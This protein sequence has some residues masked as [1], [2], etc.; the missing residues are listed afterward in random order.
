MSPSFESRTGSTKEARLEKV[1]VVE[2]TRLASSTLLIVS[3]APWSIAIP[4]SCF[5]KAGRPLR[6]GRRK[7][8]YREVV[9]PVRGV[10]TFA[11]AEPKTKIRQDGLF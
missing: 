9:S 4:R 8:A 5:A 3:Q 1:E 10:E 11:K 2:P 7:P 6:M